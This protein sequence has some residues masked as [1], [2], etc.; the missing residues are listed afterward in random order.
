MSNH[1]ICGKDSVTNKV[2]GIHASTGDLHIKIDATNTNHLSNINS[3]IGIDTSDS[4]LSLTAL[5]RVQKDVIDSKLGSIMTF[6]DN[7]PGN[8]IYQRLVDINTKLELLKLE[9]SIQ[10]GYIFNNQSISASTT[11][12]SSV[13]TQEKHIEFVFYGSDST[14]SNGIIK[15]LISDDNINF[16]ESFELI[17]SISGSIYGRFPIYSKYFK[18]TFNNT[19]ASSTNIILKYS[20]KN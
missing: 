2:H 14:N 10:N 15:V 20:S 8:T 19:S 6:L 13:I 9:K 5:T 1:I 7:D 16:Y 3:R 11:Y 4:P 12:T 17:Q 18:I